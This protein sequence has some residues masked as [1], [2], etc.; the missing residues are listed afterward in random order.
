MVVFGVGGF[1]GC[2]CIDR[3]METLNKIKYSNIG[4]TIYLAL[5]TK[6]GLNHKL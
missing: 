2:N 6:T 3:K 4:D 5:L 1:F